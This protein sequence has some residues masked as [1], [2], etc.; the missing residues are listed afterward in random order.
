[1][2]GMDVKAPGSE[3][4]GG[5]AGEGGSSLYVRPSRRCK[6]GCGGRR[7]VAAGPVLAR[8]G[9]SP[10]SSFSFVTNRCSSHAAGSL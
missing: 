9:S 6:G 4:G 7:T 2:S 1:M 5:A 8:A 10:Q 3:A